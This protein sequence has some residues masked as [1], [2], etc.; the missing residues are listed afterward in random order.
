MSES[1][2]QAYLPLLVWPSLGLLLFR[3]LPADFPR[4]LGRGLYWVGIP[5]EIFTL[6]HRTDFAQTIGLAPLFAVIGLGI[7]LLLALGCLNPGN[8]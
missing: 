4:W 7:G 1:L 2:L 5:L 8:I 6:T 3:F